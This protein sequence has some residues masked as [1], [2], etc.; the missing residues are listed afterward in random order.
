MSAMHLRIG[1][2]SASPGVVMALWRAPYD[3]GVKRGATVSFITEII[4]ENPLASCKCHNTTALLPI[5]GT[6]SEIRIGNAPFFREI[7][8]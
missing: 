3:I 2:L 1:N 7:C 8:E 5:F 6:N 4:Q